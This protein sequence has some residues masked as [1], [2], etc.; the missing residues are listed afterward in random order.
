[1]DQNTSMTDGDNTI[2][3]TSA[4]VQASVQ[5]VPGSIRNIQL[6]PSR[7]SIP[8]GAASSSHALPGV[9]RLLAQ[10]PA[11]FSHIPVGRTLPPLLPALATSM[12]LRDDLVVTGQAS[13]A[14]KG[15]PGSATEREEPMGPGE[16]Q[17]FRVKKGTFPPL[18]LGVAA[19]Y[20]IREE[21]QA[22]FEEFF[23]A[24]GV[25]EPIPWKGATKKN[26]G[27]QLKVLY[28]Y[29]IMI[30]YQGTIELVRGPISE[31]LFG[32]IKFIVK[33]DKR[34]EFDAGPFPSLSATGIFGE[35]KNRDSK[36]KQMYKLWQTAGFVQRIQG[37]SGDLEFEFKAELE[38]KVKD[39]VAE[40]RKGQKEKI[41]M[42]ADV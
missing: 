38:Q 16:H 23:E 29:L 11:A 15:N 2:L 33:K 4:V 19:W 36:Y 37:K 21:K 1:M 18:H 9:M 31:G 41:T 13:E 40:T 10:I 25:H 26:T 42:Q 5:V 14:G 34:A 7:G 6:L 12:Q 22:E 17:R 8:L 24:Q 32:I 30:G 35:A 39:Q 27:N 20:K 3:R 28:L